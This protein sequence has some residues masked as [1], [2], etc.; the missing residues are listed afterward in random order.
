MS[1]EQ[2]FLEQLAR[3]PLDDMTRQV[4]ADWLQERGDPRGDYLRLEIE[5]AG[6]RDG[7]RLGERE[8]LGRQLR[9]G[10]DPAWLR[11]A[12]KPFDVWLL[13]YPSPRKIPIIKAIRELTGVG[14]KEAK[15]LSEQLPSRILARRSRAEAERV[16]DYLASASYPYSQPCPP[17]PNE[18][19]IEPS[20]AASP[21]PSPFEPGALPVPAPR[22]A[23]RVSLSWIDPESRLLVIRALREATGQPLHLCG[24]MTRQ[25]MPVVV[26]SGV[27]WQEAERIRG[28]FPDPDDVTIE[29]VY[30]TRTGCAGSG[31]PEL[32][33]Q[34]RAAQQQ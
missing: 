23:F 24:A 34:L 13:G 25:V 27:G 30:P 6:L 32:P 11:Q 21:S 28:L 20:D 19:C 3:D 18:V 16:R 9:E 26:V 4:Y 22:G 5:L 8:A 7:P 29:S 14:L 12:G 1:E 31:S 33:V 17:P 10:V 2:A 15:E